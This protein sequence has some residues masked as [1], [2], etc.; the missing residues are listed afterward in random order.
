MDAGEDMDGKK[1]LKIRGSDKP[2]R[3]METFCDIFFIQEG[4]ELLDDSCD[5]LVRTNSC[6]TEQDPPFS[7]LIPPPVNLRTVSSQPF[8]RDF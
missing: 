1:S 7:T 4:I 3:I 8:E 2:D 6:D 5:A